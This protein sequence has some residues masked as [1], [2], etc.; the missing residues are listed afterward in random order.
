MEQMQ[1]IN[2]MSENHTA[3]HMP[4]ASIPELEYR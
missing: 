2:G 4:V 1:Q 3:H